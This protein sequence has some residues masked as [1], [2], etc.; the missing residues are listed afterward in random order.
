MKH[1]SLIIVFFSLLFCSCA[2]QQIANAPPSTYYLNQNY[3]N[4]FTDTTVVE[5]GVPDIRPNAAPWI[6][7]VVFDRFNQKQ[8]IL[9]DNATQKAGQFKVTWYGKGADGFKVPPGVY[10]IELEQINI[11][12][13][14]LGEEVFTLLR[15]AALKQ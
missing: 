7:I 3:P 11:S 5:F 10:Y 6:R 8:A 14:S 2:E 13:S 9:I 12:A 15:I 1:L 4:P